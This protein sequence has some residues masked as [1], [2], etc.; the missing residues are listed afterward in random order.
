[1][2]DDYEKQQLKNLM[3]DNKRLRAALA[4]IAK[5]IITV[6]ETDDP[7]ILRSRWGELAEML[8]VVLHDYADN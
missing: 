8:E 2:I 4:Q 3:A 7:K 5:V 6:Q 1:M